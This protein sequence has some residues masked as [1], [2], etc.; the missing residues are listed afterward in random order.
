M[1]GA[2]LTAVPGFA[3]GGA[4]KPEW[5]QRSDRITQQLLDIRFDGCPEE[6]SQEGVTRYDPLVS[7]PTV[8]HELELVERKKALAARLQASLVG[9]K[10]VR[11]VQDYKI[12]LDSIREDLDERDYSETHNVVFR[13]PHSLV[14]DGLSFLL[15]AQTAAERRPAVVDR[16][17]K[18]AGLE[19]GTQPLCEVL[20]ARMQSQMDKPAML[21]P[22]RS[23]VETALARSS[24]LVAGLE[25]LLQESQLEGWQEPF[26]TLK[27]QLAAYD[28]WL[29]EAVLPRARQDFRLGHEAYARYFAARGISGITPE[30]L[31]AEAH[32]AYAEIQS[33]MA[34][35]AARIAQERHLPSSD[36]RDVMKVLKA[37]QIPPEAILGVYQ[38]RL[39]QIEGLVRE[40]DIVTLPEGQAVIRTATE[41]EAALVPGPQMIP[42]P[43]VKNTGQRGNFVI[44]LRSSDGQKF[45]DFTY[46]AIS[47]SVTAHE[48]RPGHELQFDSMVDKGVSKA[49]AIYAANSAN[50]EGWGLYCEWL[51]LPYMPPEGQLASLDGRL[52]RAARAFLDSELHAGKITL[53]EARRLLTEDVLLSPSMVNSE[54]RRYTFDEPAQACSYFYG[55]NQLRQLRD[56]T[57]K[58]MGAKFSA[59]D[60]HNFVLDQGLLPP[61]LLRETVRQHFLR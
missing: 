43:L 58:A 8:A 22:S 16:I 59:R 7:T 23:E 46:D 34:E 17:R 20:R 42:P 56:E 44:P 24:Q 41:A 31:A 57:E 3:E 40:H 5:I 47:W 38:E 12:L 33:Q 13:D 54:I 27:L 19:A 48:A 36:Y 39:K 18:Y 10:D 32:Q 4:E 37:E 2:G 26:Q 52:L 14:N 15:D 49:R 21:Y 30:Q 28:A 53:E 25:K 6:G 51:I 50:I 61:P 45:D 55:Y 11:L 60:F 9:E 1:I 35:V 29:K